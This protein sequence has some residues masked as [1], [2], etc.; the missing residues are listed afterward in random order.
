MSVLVHTKHRYQILFNLAIAE[1]ILVWIYAEQ[2]PSLPRMAPRLFKLVIP[3]NLRLIMLISA[4]LSML[5]VMIFLFFV[6]TTIPY[7]FAFHMPLLVTSQSLLLTLP[8]RAM[9]S[10]KQ[11]VYGPATN[12]DGCVVFMECFL[13]DLP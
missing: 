13:H 7:A 10:V 5:L 3:S 8:V 2:V 4:L 1:A 12:E 9:S 11:V 6:L